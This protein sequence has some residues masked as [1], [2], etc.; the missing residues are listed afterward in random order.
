MFHIF[1]T[2]ALQSRSFLSQ[3][4][5]TGDES[6]FFMSCHKDTRFSIK[7]SRFHTPFPLLQ[8]KKRG[9]DAGTATHVLYALIRFGPVLLCLPQ[10]FLPLLYL[11]REMLVDELSQRAGVD[12]ETPCQ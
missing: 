3:R 10:Q 11:L 5:D 4:S 1:L 9:R 2:F 12:T 7:P 6:V 8:Y